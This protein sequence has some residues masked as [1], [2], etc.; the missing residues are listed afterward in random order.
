MLLLTPS[1]DANG[2]ITNLVIALDLVFPTVLGV[3]RIP[4]TDTTPG[5]IIDDTTDGTIDGTIAGCAPD[6][7]LLG[8]PYCKPSCTTL[9]LAS[10]R[11]LFS[12]VNVDIESKFKSKLKFSTVVVIVVRV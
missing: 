1:T 11:A 5:T 9:C 7:M 6:T 2:G 3:A 4:V 12:T 10:W 8:A